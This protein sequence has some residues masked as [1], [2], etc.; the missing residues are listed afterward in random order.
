VAS[1]AIARMHKHANKIATTNFISTRS[2]AMRT[3][4]EVPLKLGFE[5]FVSCHFSKPQVQDDFDEQV[6][7]RLS[8]PQTPKH[9]FICK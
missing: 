6:R 2:R 1:T 4:D 8:K 9:I 3:A 5:L 7:F